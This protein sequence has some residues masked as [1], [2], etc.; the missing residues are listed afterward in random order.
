MSINVNVDDIRTVT[1]VALVVVVVV[2]GGGCVHDGFGHFDCANSFEHT[3][4][5]LI[6]DRRGIFN[7]LHGN[8]D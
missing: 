7:K 3:L 8:T 6:R 2:G 1:V 4:S 5:V